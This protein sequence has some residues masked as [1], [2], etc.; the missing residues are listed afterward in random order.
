MHAGK[1]IHG[2]GQFPGVSRK[3]PYMRGSQ[4][5]QGQ[6]IVPEMG[7]LA[8]YGTLG[9][10]PHLGDDGRGVHRQVPDLGGDG[11]AAGRGVHASGIS[12]QAP[13]LSADAQGCNVQTTSIY[14]WMQRLAER[15]RRVRICCGD[16]SRIMGPAGTVHVGTT[17]VLLDPPYRHDG[18]DDDVYHHDGSDTFAAAKS[19]AI[20]HGDDQQYRIVLCGY[21]GEAMPASWRLHT[22]QARGGYG[23]QGTGRGKENRSRECLWISRHCVERQRSLFE[24]GGVV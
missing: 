12:R 6:G 21:E 3:L 24:I 1:T 15:L 18:R 16:W 17:G 7:H 4:G 23:N 8:E 19:W 14:D 20:A 9:Y 5:I 13:R 10:V 11:S 2:V 22:W